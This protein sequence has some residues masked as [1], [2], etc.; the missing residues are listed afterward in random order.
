MWASPVSP[1]PSVAF[2]MAPPITDSVVV[3]VVVVLLLLYIHRHQRCQH[4]RPTMPPT[5]QPLS[6]TEQFIP[7]YQLITRLAGRQLRQEV[8]EAAG[9]RRAATHHAHHHPLQKGRRK[10]AAR[11]VAATACLS[12]P[13]RL[14][15]PPPAQQGRRCVAAAA[16]ARQIGLLH[17]GRGRYEGFQGEECTAAHCCTASFLSCC[18]SLRPARPPPPWTPWPPHPLRGQGQGQGQDFFLFLSL[19]EIPFLSNLYSW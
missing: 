11:F 6:N 14:P 1:R 15:P 10:Q 8:K 4:H 16:A 18:L 7:R 13:P 9:A 2:I 19:L 12:A 17:Q 3:V 5:T